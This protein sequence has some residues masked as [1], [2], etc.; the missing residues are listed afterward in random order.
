ML[1]RRTAD[2]LL[3]LLALATV[4]LVGVVVLRDP[5]PSSSSSLGAL[6]A[7]VTPSPAATPTPTPTATAVPVPV[8]ALL[9]VDPAVPSGHLTSAARTLGWSLGAP[10]P[11]PPGAGLQARLVGRRV[12]L[13]QAQEGSPTVAA[14]AVRQ[15]HTLAPAV[16][17]VLVGPLGFGGGQLTGQRDQLRDAATATGADF[18]DPVGSRWLASPRTPPT[19]SPAEQDDL[20][21]RLVRAVQGADTARGTSI[22]PS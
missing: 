6:P 2:V 5:T 15:V 16:R 11:L 18:V 21:Q 9:L 19:L 17:V 22:A 4:A 1:S 12:V 13:V 8:P 3:V 20:A 14:E 7:P 10:L